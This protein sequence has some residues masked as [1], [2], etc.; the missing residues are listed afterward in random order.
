MITANMS[1]HDFML[2]TGEVCLYSMLILLA[3]GSAR[4]EILREIRKQGEFSTK[5][6]K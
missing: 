4:D 2:I 3:I 6:D 1:M 5:S